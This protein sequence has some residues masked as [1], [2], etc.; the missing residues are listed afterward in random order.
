MLMVLGHSGLGVEFL[1]KFI[2][3][4]HMPLFFF[5]S[6]YCFKRTYLDEP[7]KFLLRRVKGLYWPF[8]KWSLVFLALHNVCFLLNIYNG[9]YGFAGGVSHMYGWR[10]FAERGW[11]IVACMNKQ[12]QLV[13]GYWFLKQLFLG[14]IIAWMLLKLFRCFE[15]GGGIALITSMLCNKVVLVTPLLD[16]SSQTFASATLIIAGHC[17]AQHK[18]RPFPLWTVIS[19][20]IVTAIGT[21]YWY[22]E[23]GD[24]TYSNKVFPFYMLTAVLM[25]WSI[26]SL[27][28]RYAKDRSLRLLTFIGNNTLTILTWHFLSF[29]LVSLVI[30]G[31]YGLPIARLAEFPIIGEYSTQGWWVLYFLSGVMLPLSIVLLKDKSLIAVSERR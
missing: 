15:L 25:S 4:F 27:F 1:Q 20:T 28:D 16:L 13:G 24:V 12:E 23:F 26:Y 14:S 21:Q 5:A 29:K 10:E 6:G 19:S 3:M 30:I 22:M 9:E 11:H 8:V 7:G 31:I 2:Y 18:V 17:F